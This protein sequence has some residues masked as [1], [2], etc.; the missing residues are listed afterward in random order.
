MAN[1]PTV[2]GWSIVDHPLSP[3]FKT[4]NFY[5]SDTVGVVTSPWTQSTQTQ[6]WNGADL[7]SADVSLPPMPRVQASVWIAW[8]KALRGRAN[9]FQ[10]GD[11]AGVN[12]QGLPT[13]TPVINGAHNAGATTINTRGWAPNISQNLAPDDY[14]QI[15]YYLYSV[16]QLTTV[17]SDANGEAAI[18]IWPSLR[19]APPDGEA[20]IL[21]NTSGIFR[22]ADNTRSWNIDEA[23]IFGMQ[24]KC[25]EA[26]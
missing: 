14:I 17:D 15:G 26:R 24:F 16:A 7:W 5:A 1:Y 19:A 2:N 20:L 12:P 4:I 11:P 13:G 9:V 3:G 10:L 21:S 22:L 8:L 6:I 23:H 18:D 25:V